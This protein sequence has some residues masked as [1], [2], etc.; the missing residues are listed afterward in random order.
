M[1]IKVGAVIAAAGSSQRMGNV[2]KVFVPLGGKPLLAHVLDTFQRCRLIDQIVVV[3]SQENLEKCRELVAGQDWDKISDVLAGGKRRQD[4]VANGLG[5]L[6]ACDWVVIHDGARPLVTTEL[7]KRGLEAAR[8][9]GA[10]IA[11]VPLSDT[12]KLADEDG[13]VLGTPPRHHLWRVQTPQVFRH[14]LITS[15]YRN[16]Q[17]EVTD[18]AALVE[19][20]GYRVKLYPGDEKNLK[21]TTPADLAL[22]EA[23][24]SYVK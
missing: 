13:F 15:A 19:R 3:V 1:K 11:A 12:I 17:A 18:D 23:L 5:K 14:D 2:D 6:Q 20:A 22:A 9:S 8:E 24:L 16:L 7:I 21:I 4:S 10:A